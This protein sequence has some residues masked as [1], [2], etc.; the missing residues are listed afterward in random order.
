MAMEASQRPLRLRCSVQNYDWGRFGEES[1]VARLFRRN[2]GKEIELGRPY[3]EFWMGTHESGPSFVVAAEGSGT[4]A[5]TLKKWTGA[6][7]GALGNKVVEKWGND[8]PFLFKILSVAKALSIQAH[9]D[10]ELARMLHKMRPSV[11][12]DPNHKPE[13]AIALTEF[14]ALC[15]FVSIEE[16][17]DVLVA[18]PEITQLLGNDE[19]SKILSQD[20]NGYVDAKSFLQL[21]FTKLMTASKEAV[22]EL[23]SKLKARL[24][25]ENKIRTL[26]EK[27][28]L[29]LLLEKQYQADV[30]VIAAFLFNYVKLSPGE[31]LYIGP[32]EP[33]AY[34]SGECI[35]CM[36][37][38]DNVVRAGLTPK[39]IDKQTLCSMLTYKQGF[40]VILRGSPINPYVSRFR[41]PFDEFEVDR[42]LLPSKESVEF[43]AIPGPSIFVVVAG[44][45]RME[46][47]S[48]VEELK[49]M[50]GDVY[51]VPAQT[52]IRLSACADGPIKLYRAGVNSRIF[53]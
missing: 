37:T 29:V 20:L 47:S 24:D 51:F 21:V 31:A 19:A 32:N 14:K 46:V 45:G 11:Y 35:E 10:K 41:P 34:I 49:I 38:S 18:V 6:N 30:G 8:L 33:H 25:L 22:S 48:V 28:Q 53:A 39:Y 15:G 4:E 52:E 1:T 27:E 44:E 36:A 16:L 40:P 43:S 26:T 7:P 3:A 17:K 13:M 5:V 23:V 42:C 12:K 9:P 2:S 50:E